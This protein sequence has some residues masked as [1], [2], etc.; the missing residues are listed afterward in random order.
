MLILE[1]L[2]KVIFNLLI[3][4]Y[5]NKKVIKFKNLVVIFAKKRQTIKSLI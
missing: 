3:K 4:K 1:Q 2:N 5:D